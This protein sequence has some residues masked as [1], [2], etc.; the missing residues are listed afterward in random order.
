MEYYKF[1]AQDRLKD[2]SLQKNAVLNLTEEIMRLKSEAS[3]IKSATGDGTSVKGG[4]S[5]REER[6]LSNF[7]KKE[8]C[9]L[10]LNRAKHAVRMVDRG[11]SALS[12]ED[13][14]LLDV[15]Y[16]INEPKKVERLMQELGLQEPSSLYKRVNKALYR[17]TVAMYGATEN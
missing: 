12:A 15:M 1:R 11:L 3:S 16:A 4:G 5:G 17:F 2:Y 6:L 14:H 9:R 7:V 10:L 8:E 13:K